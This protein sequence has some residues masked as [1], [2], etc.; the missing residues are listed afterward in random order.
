MPFL[1]DSISAAIAAHGLTIDRLLHPLVNVKRA[2]DGRLLAL[3]PRS[4]AGTARESMIY[5]ETPRAD[6]RTR[7]RLRDAL[8]SVLDDVRASVADWPSLQAAMAA[9]ANRL[10][11]RREHEGA[12]LL[13]WF[14]AG[15]LTQLGHVVRKRDGSQSGSLG[16]CRKSARTLLQPRNCDRAFAWFDKAERA[17]PLILKAN[18]L[19]NVHRRVPLDLFIVPLRD[20]GGKVTALSI[21]AGVWTSAAMQA[22]PRE[23]PVMREQLAATMKKLGVDP[24]DHDG[25]ALVH[26]LTALPHDVLVGFEAG[27][28]ERIATTMMSLVDRPRPRLVLVRS[29]LARHLFAF[30]WLPRDAVST[31]LRLQV[32]AMLTEAAQAN[33][34]DWSLEVD[35]TL[36]LLRFTLDIR[37][38]A[39]KVDE[40][41]LA[42][43]LTAMVRGWGEAVEAELAE[44]EDPARAAAV[45]ARY[46]DAFPLGYR[47]TN[48]A[49]EA[50]QD[51]L[52][53]RHL[54]VNHD[55]GE[56]RRDARL[57]SR[58]GVMDDRLDLKIYQRRGSLPLSDAVPMLENFGFRVVREIPTTLR[59]GELGSI[60]DFDLELPPTFSEGD[61]L[62][63]RDVI[64][65]AVAAVLNAEAE[66]DAFNRLVCSVRLTERE[67]N[68]LRAWHR[69]LRQ[70]G[71]SYGLVT[72][73]QA[74]ERAPKVTR[75]LLDLF[76]ARHDPDFRGDRTKAENAA[77]EAIRDGLAAVDAINDDRLLRHYRALIGAIV[78]TNAYAPRPA[79]GSVALA[80]KIDSAQVPGLPMPL[81][82]REVFVYSR[83]VEGIHLRAGP[84]ARGGL[85]WSDRRDDYR[86]EVLGL[87][88]AQMV[89]NAVIVP[90]G[91]KGGFV[92]KTPTSSRE[93]F[94][95]EGIECYKIFIRGLLDITDNLAGAK[96]IPPKDVVRRDG[97]DPYL[98]VAA[99]KGTATFSDTANAISQEYG[100]WMGDAFASG[101]SAGYDHKKM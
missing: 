19:S 52:R 24:G 87:M 78:R 7:V 86:T 26:A 74:L 73:V 83:R 12:A 93:E 41:D 91:A 30:V 75:G 84:V 39:A 69:Y 25:K 96:V 64:E 36:A 38:G 40:A 11:D 82:W 47:A 100:F 37:Q 5:I 34:L 65:T 55:D 61:L 15:M 22:A 8:A 89:K 45:A 99:D 42:H 2:E 98:V 17:A 13:R 92:V 57:H 44:R 66:D 14:N 1:V 59:D 94:M 79:D 60:H 21:H 33:V 4:G 81:P 28:L 85:R 90:M 88:K 95:R 54:D 80:F 50:A 63:R 16:M 101:G 18:R 9:D 70:A 27:E 35:G 29:P 3:P 6:A 53:L 58:T 76:A 51:I 46:A 10:D 71:S 62:A 20:A 31:A 49:V 77:T 48:G 97:D 67:A 32:Q 72:T 43:Q 56:T 23:V 68:W